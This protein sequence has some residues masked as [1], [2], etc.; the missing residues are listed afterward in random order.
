MDYIFHDKYRQLFSEHIE[1]ASNYINNLQDEDCK[2]KVRPMTMRVS[3]ERTLYDIVWILQ[4]ANTVF[5]LIS[6]L[7]KICS[8][9]WASRLEQ[10]EQMHLSLLLKMIALPNFNA[11]MNSL[12]EVRPKIWASAADEPDGYGLF[13]S[14]PK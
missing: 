8:A 5:H 13:S 2:A 9:V 7:R 6:T 12:K 14:L 11:K 4:S 10:I 1:Q 3:L